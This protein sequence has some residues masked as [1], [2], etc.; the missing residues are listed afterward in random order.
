MSFLSGF[1]SDPRTGL[2]GPFSADA[3]R[4]STSIRSITIDVAALAPTL[5]NAYYAA[6]RMMIVEYLKKLIEKHPLA[7]LMVGAIAVRLLAV[8][9]SRG[10]MASDD[11]FETV[12][13]AYP[14]L[15][16]G[17]LADNG[18]LTW[19]HHVPGDIA[20]FPLYNLVLYGIMK[21]CHVLGL[22]SLDSMMYV[23]RGV[24]GALSLLSVWAVY[25]LVEVVTRSVRWAWLGGAMIAFHM[26]MPYLAVRNLIEMVGG[27]LWIVALYFLYRF[28]DDHRDRWIVVAG[29]MTGLA[30]MIRFEVAFA[31]IAIPFV[32]WIDYRRLAVVARYLTGV[33]VMLIVA[34][35][36]DWWLLGSFH[37]STVH[38]IGQVLTESPP[39]QTSLLIYPGVL[40]L[41]FLPPFSLVA[42]YLIGVREFWRK[43]KLL[44]V[45]SL[46]FVLAHSFSASRQERYMISIVP[47]LMA[48]ITL[49]LWHHKQRGGKLFRRRYLLG[50][51]ISITLLLNT[52]GLALLTF[53]YSHKDVVEPLVWAERVVTE[54]DPEGRVSGVF[55]SPERGQIYPMIYGGMK[56]MNRHRIHRWQD[57]E[58]LHPLGDEAELS[59][60]YILYPQSAGDRRRFED[61]LVARI[62]PVEQ[63]LEVQPS[64]VDHLAHKLN[65]KHNPARV[66]YV[67]RRVIK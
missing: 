45:S 31:A 42:F 59:R 53:N 55:M 9:F 15:C 67:F 29:I 28:V 23:V 61:S 24:H 37:A 49:A 47:V 44:V 2:A 21:V 38:H 35:L 12:G 26:A 62:G 54:R 41:F 3:D 39:Y 27:H 65:P 63:M 32:L 30:W 18:L 40:L 13:V 17:L 33:L 14:W 1:G 22:S 25:R 60:F 56:F 52:V 10:F 57:M 43:H 7:T 66:A 20:R 11:H 58:S 8:I 19:G 46:V 6:T 34:G 64:F 50:G 51:L 48:T 16:E 36:V 4:L 5:L